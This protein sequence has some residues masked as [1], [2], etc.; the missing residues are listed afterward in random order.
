[1]LDDDATRAATHVDR[2]HFQP[3]TR[4]AGGKSAVRFIWLTTF[5]FLPLLAPSQARPFQA[6]RLG[7]PV[8]ISA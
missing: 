3:A 7:A 5:I 1:M 6:I 2:C 4:R 8:T